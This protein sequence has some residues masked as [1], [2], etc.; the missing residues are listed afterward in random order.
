MNIYKYNSYYEVTEVQQNTPLFNKIDWTFSCFNF[1]T[2]TRYGR[3]YLNIGETIRIP[4]TVS[5][6]FLREIIP[7]EPIDRQT[8]A[9]VQDNFYKMTSEPRN[10]IQERATDFLIGEGVHKVLSLNTNA[11]K[12]FITINAISKMKINAIVLVDTINLGEQWI[13]EIRKHTNAKNIQLI[14]ADMIERDLVEDANIFIVTQQSID[15]LMLRNY[16]KINEFMKEK[17]IGIKVFD[18]SH[19]RF[20]QLTR[21]NNIFNTSKTIYLTATFDRNYTEVSQWKK[22]FSGVDR[23]IEKTEERY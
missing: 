2:K 9:I 4:S 7:K 22:V 18:E 12:T 21:I 1:K 8:D 10:D 20:H 15:S 16:N 14:D 11:G 3:L 13:Q 6:E 19:S 23:M 5:E 17:Q